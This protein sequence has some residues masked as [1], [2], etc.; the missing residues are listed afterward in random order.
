MIEGLMKDNNKVLCYNGKE[1]SIVSCSWY[2]N[3]VCIVD[4]KEAKRCYEEE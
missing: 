4:E 3:G 1:C 2:K